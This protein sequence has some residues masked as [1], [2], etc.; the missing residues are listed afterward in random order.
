MYYKTCFEKN[1]TYVGQ[2]NKSGLEYLDGL[3]IAVFETNGTE[4]VS[5][6]VGKIIQSR[7]EAKSSLREIGALQQLNT[8]N[9]L[10]TRKGL[11]KYYTL[12]N[13]FLPRFWR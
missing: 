1:K 12:Q 4:F 8:V 3:K 2:R 6:T 7:H 5:V 13:L 10:A 9:N 11:S